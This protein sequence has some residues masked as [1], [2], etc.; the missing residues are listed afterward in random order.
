MRASHI[1]TILGVLAVFGVGAAVFLMIRRED[2]PRVVTVVAPPP[3]PHLVDAGIQ[4]QPAAAPPAPQ[5]QPVTPRDVA[6]EISALRGEALIGGLWALE[7]RS[8]RSVT[9]AALERSPTRFIGS[10][11][12]FSGKILE[13]QDIP[14]QDGSFLRLGLDD[15]GTKVLA[16]FAL[17][18]PADGIVR[19]SRI[20]VYGTIDAPFSY[21]S[22]AGWNITIPR[23]NALAVVP[24]SVP[25][26]ARR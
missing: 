16:V 8:D 15:Y 11:V 6:L 20:R 21:Q 10:L 12:V 3:A 4:A 26:R 1:S 13:I 9:H 17:V 24:N 5:P 25:R 23:V 14:N 22:Q 19:G 7:Q 2:P 18:R